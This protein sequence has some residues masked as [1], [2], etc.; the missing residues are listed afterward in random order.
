MFFSGD[1]HKEKARQEA[2]SARASVQ[3]CLL[4]T[5]CEGQSFSVVMKDSLFQLRALLTV[6]CFP[7]FQ[8]YSFLARRT[9]SKFNQIVMKR[10]C[11]SRV[12]RPPM[13]LS[14]LVSTLSR[15]NICLRLF[16]EQKWKKN[17]PLFLTTRWKTWK[18]EVIVR[19]WPALLL[20]PSPMIS[21]FMTSQNSRFVLWNENIDWTKLQNPGLVF[22]SN[23]G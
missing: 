16:I 17:C 23:M 13:S 4:K 9:K 15:I 3:E 6:T 12:N 21:E 5:S 14:R 19:N 22:L 11:F 2:H 7:L 8:L 1:R 18:L 10:L 20:E